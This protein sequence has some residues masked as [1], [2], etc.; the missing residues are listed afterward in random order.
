MFGLSEI[1][2]DIENI[3]KVLASVGHIFIQHT[4][5]MDT[6]SKR[7]DELQ[8]QLDSLRVVRDAEEIARGEKP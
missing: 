3:L 1:K 7:I 8:K 4:L 5:R 2:K 6:L